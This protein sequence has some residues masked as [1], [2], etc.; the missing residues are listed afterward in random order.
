VVSVPSRGG[1]SRSL[2]AAALILAILLSSG[3]ASAQPAT[4]VTLNEAGLALVEYV[5][6]VGGNLSITVK[7]LGSPDP[8][9]NVTVVDE[10]GLPLAFEINKS[11]GFLTAATLNC[12]QVH[13]SYYTQDLTSKSGM[14]WILTVNSP[15]QLKVVLPENATPIDMSTLP[16]NVY[17]L[18]KRLVLEYPPGS[19]QLKY[20]LLYQPVAPPPQAPSQPPSTP[21]QPPPTPPQAPP[22]APS[23]PPSAPSEIPPS[24]IPYILAAV[25]LTAVIIVLVLSR[26]R[27]TAELVELGEEDLAIIEALRNAGGAMFQGE[28][29]RAVNLPA[30][31]LWRR[32]KRLEELGYLKVE[33]RAGRNYVKL[34]W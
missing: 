7:L 16:S 22:Q 20:I 28:L 4:T 6:P 26:R 34:V 25:L 31:T 33:K 5:V 15:Y 21:S 3:N 17:P 13:V 2:F 1:A 12:S 30:T 23:R 32:V 18:G 9:L 11:T 10:R 27:R 29:Q 8:T 19:L 14:Y 24:L